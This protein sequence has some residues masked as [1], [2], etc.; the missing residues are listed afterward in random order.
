MIHQVGVF[1]ERGRQI[2]LA[3][4]GKNRDDALP[5]LQL[6][7]DLERGVCDGPRGDADEDAFLFC[8]TP[9]G[10]HCLIERDVELFV[11]DLGVVNCRHEARPDALQF[12]R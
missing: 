5:F 12:V 9:R 10:L 8:Q 7:R 4:I 6:L 11:D 1:E 3:G 2:A